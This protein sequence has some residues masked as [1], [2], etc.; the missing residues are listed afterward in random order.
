MLELFFTLFP[1]T[2]AKRR[3]K[4]KNPKNQT[5]QNKLLKH[6]REKADKT[7]PLFSQRTIHE[8]NSFITT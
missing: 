1:Q 3:K 4:I 5:R 7:S 8:Y 6:Q 2:R